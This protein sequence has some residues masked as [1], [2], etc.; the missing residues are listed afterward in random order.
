MNSFDSSKIELDH[1]E[2]WKIVMCDW[3]AFAVLR[4]AFIEYFFGVHVLNPG[5]HSECTLFFNMQPCRCC[6]A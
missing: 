1:I 2:L 3:L 4:N 5:S 6:L